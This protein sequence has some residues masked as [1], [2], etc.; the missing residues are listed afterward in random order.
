MFYGLFM[1]GIQGQY[2]IS[3]SPQTISP[4]WAL[5]VSPTPCSPLA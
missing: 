1:Y 5:V 3:P 2:S 4:Y